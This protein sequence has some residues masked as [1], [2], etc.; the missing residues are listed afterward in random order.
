MKMLNITAQKPDSTGSGVYLA[1]M[2]NSFSQC[3]HEQAIIAGIS[4]ADAPIFPEGVLFH[5]V[6]FGSDE[7]PFAVVGM[8]DEMPYTS[9][10]YRDMTPL[11]VSQFEHAFIAALDEVFSQF[12]PDIIICHHLYLL[13]AIVREYL[14]REKVLAVSHSTDLRQMQKHQLERE[15]IRAAV[16]KLDAVLALHEAQKQEIIDLYDIDES[17]IHVIGTGFNSKIFCKKESDSSVQKAKTDLIF[18]GKIWEKKGVVSLIRAL[19][20]LSYSPDE[21]T[22]RLVGGHATEEEYQRIYD[23][24]ARSAYQIEFL[25]KYPQNKLAEEYRKSDVFV[26]PSFFEGLP[27]VAIEALACGCKVVITDLPGIR[28][29]ISSQVSDAPVFYVEPPDMRN[30]DE[31]KPESI[32]AFEEALARVIEESIA[33]PSVT[34]E[35]GHLAWSGLC[36]RVQKVV[37]SL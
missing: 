4:R 7:L 13:T 18:V 35:L 20:L 10:R 21:I 12:T 6:Y 15:R 9:T 32:P 26:L 28:S 1:E 27:L 31:P 29:W 30:T 22:L 2:V 5:P 34:C 24:A 8:S 19:D 36:D 23:L 11:M 14:P 16:R 25:G 17:N 3:G 33:A 37:D